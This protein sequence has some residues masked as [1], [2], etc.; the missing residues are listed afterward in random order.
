MASHS[1]AILGA[2]TQGRKLA[3]MVNTASSSFTNPPGN[4]VNII[5]RDAAQ[6]KAAE[7][8]VL[9]LWSTVGKSTQHK[10]GKISI[11]LAD[12][13]RRAME[14]A[15]LVIEVGYFLPSL[16]DLVEGKVVVMARINSAS[17]NR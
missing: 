8:E 5:D 9:R 4:P 16:W 13:R 7:A 15:W 1:A 14:D 12:D 10:G 2:G 11:T 3:Y 17:R 6:L